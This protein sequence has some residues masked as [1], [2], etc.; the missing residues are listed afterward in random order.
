MSRTLSSPSPS[1]DNPPALQEYSLSV[2]VPVYNEQETLEEIVGR[3]LQIEEV[4]QVVLVNDGSDSETTAII[5]HLGKNNRVMVI[6]HEINQGKGAALRSG[7]SVCTGDI[8][9]IQDADLEY[10]PE[11][12]PR[13]AA[14]IAEGSVDVVYGSRWRGPDCHR[15]PLVRRLAN[16]FL[17]WLSNR[18][19]GLALTDMET[20]TKVF[21]SN[22]I[23]RIQICEDRFGVE[24][25]LTAKIAAGN[26]RLVEAPIGY[27]PRGYNEGKKIGIR[28]GLRAL[29]C[30]VWYRY[31]L[32]GNVSKEEGFDA[33]K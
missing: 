29:W 23:Q 31:R 10:A 11:E 13:L 8:L 15:A 1:Q 17:T 5:D 32:E 6:R 4:S 7:F 9:A 12:L 18:L 20:G 14:M 3:L 2:V 27:S 25:E 19:N 21:S 16:R 30:I 26:W 33:S 28:D 22:V 24:P